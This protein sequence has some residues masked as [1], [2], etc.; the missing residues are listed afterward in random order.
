MRMLLAISALIGLGAAAPAWADVTLRYKPVVP[1]TASAPP[2]GSVPILTVAADD[3]G[4]ARIE[5]VAPAGA[6]GAA[7]GASPPS[8]ALI[9]R[10]GVGY[11]ALNGPQAGQQIVARQDDVLAIVTPLASGLAGGS[12]REGVQEMMRQRVEVVPLGT[13][14]VAGVQGRLYRIVM[15][16]GETRSPPIEIVLSQDPRLAPAGREL[17]RLT[18]SLRPIVVAVMGGEPQV[19][20][21]VRA[22][23]VQGTPLRLTNAFVLDSF[24]TEDVPDSRFA[25]PGPVMSREQLGQMM[26][27]MMGRRP[28]GAAGSAGPAPAPEPAPAP[29]PPAGA[30]P[31]PQ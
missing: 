22:L 9:T 25:L 5:M 13:E 16:S 20:A 24:S 12:G 17:V 1:A 2:P 10:E 8:V 4:Q 3:A 6:A 31:H 28:P 26:G 11:V 15:I 7:P 18:D 14:S 30:P 23:L 21:A 19:Y 27:A 29:V